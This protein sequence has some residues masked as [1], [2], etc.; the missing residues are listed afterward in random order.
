MRTLS[1]IKAAYKKIER[2]ADAT[3]RMLAVRKLKVSEQLRLNEM[4]PLLDGSSELSAPDGTK[5]EVPRRT[6]PLL[7]ASVVEINGTPVPFPRSRAELDSMID[8]L[9]EPGLLAVVT[10]LGALSAADGDADSGDDAAKK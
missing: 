9:D 10:A 4:T 8:E 2:V 6:Y 5:I 3:G 1:E 7:A